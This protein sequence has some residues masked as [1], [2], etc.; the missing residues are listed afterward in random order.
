M[1][2]FTLNHNKLVS[3]FQYYLRLKDTFFLSDT[4][5]LFHRHNGAQGEE[6]FQCNQYFLRSRG[7]RIFRQLWDQPGQEGI[8]AAALQSQ[9]TGT[10]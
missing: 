5:L 6:Y 2:S 4:H 10:F 7:R 3:N 9:I 1:K 8:L